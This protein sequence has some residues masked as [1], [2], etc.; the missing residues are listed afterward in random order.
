MITAT[1]KSESTKTSDRLLQLE[2]Q[3]KEVVAK[4]LD[5]EKKWAAKLDVFGDMKQ[6]YLKE[7]EEKN[8]KIE[9]LQH[10]MIEVKKQ[11]VQLEDNMI[12]ATLKSESTKTSDRLLQLEL[13]L[14][15]VVAKSLDAEKKWAAKLDIF[16]GMKQRY[17]K[18]IEEKNNKIEELQHEMIEV[19]KQKKI[20]E[21]N[22]S[23]AVSESDFSTSETLLLLERQMK[24]VLA[25]SLE[26]E[27]RLDAKLDVINDLELKL[28]QL[29]G[30]I[31]DIQDLGATDKN[32]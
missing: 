26:Y 10:E 29:S 8:N 24:E 17:L 5:A 31:D 6:R 1:L 14:K 28:D 12:T 3:L 30:E 18:E 32:I 11:K 23:Q 2:Y 22:L 27:V 7:I 15:E 13:Q 25:K 21:D 16:E 4:S 9:E 20:A 19:K